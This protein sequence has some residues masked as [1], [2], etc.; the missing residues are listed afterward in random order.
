MSR[1]AQ[2]LLLP[3]LLAL[4][5]GC[6]DNGRPRVFPVEGQVLFNGKPPVGAQVIFHPI[7]KSG[8]DAVRPTGQVD[9]TGKFTLTTYSSNDGAPEGDYD[10]TVELWI[11]K[12]DNPAVNQLPAR[13]QQTKSSG[14]H[15]KIT[16]GENQLTAFK[17][18]R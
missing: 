14:L 3:T 4:A 15:A 17:L 2:C 9:G 12:N 8:T 10:V 16:P 13:Y 1:T 11:S 5:A 18:A 7:G 6:S